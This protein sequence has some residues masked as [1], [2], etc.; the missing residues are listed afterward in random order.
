EHPTVTLKVGTVKANVTNAL[1]SNTPLTLRVTKHLQKIVQEVTDIK[2]SCQQLIG[3]Y[4]ERL[5]TPGAFQENLD[6]ELLDKLCP[7][8]PSTITTGNGDK[9]DDEKEEE[10]RRM[11]EA[12]G[13]E[14]DHSL[15]I[16]ML[17]R[18]LHS[19]NPVSGN[20]PNAQAMRRFLKR[21]GNLGLLER[22]AKKSE[23]PGAALLGSAASQLT[24]ELDNIYR[25]V[26]D[27]HDDYGAALAAEGTHVAAPSIYSTQCFLRTD[28][29]SSDP[30]DPDFLD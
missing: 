9:T 5:S 1:D 3:R 29:P 20:T 26:L 27:D 18:H 4:I 6:R 24:V 10:L 14:T 22:N 8:I 25:R 19:R 7:R 17:M 23:L 12:L 2:R 28:L 15:F 11:R 30:V 13:K 21:L 16:G